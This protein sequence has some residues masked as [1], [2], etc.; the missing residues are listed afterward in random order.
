M[1]IIDGEVPNGSNEV[2]RARVEEP[3]EYPTGRP[4]EG[5]RGL[6]K[7]G[8]GSDSDPGDCND[9][10][11]IPTTPVQR[12][13][14]HR[15]PAVQ[16]ED[17]RGERTGDVR[18]GGKIKGY[19]GP[20][21][22]FVTNMQELAVICHSMDEAVKKHGPFPTSLQRGMILIMEEFGEVARDVADFTRS[23]GGEYSRTTPAIEHLHE[24]LSQLAGLCALMMENIA[25]GRYR[26]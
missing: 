13:D 15:G 12:L 14:I 11:E 7:S 21:N 22:R 16:A 4:I 19:Q 20:V 18:D 5:E 24:E 26:W 6:E 10:P 25:S 17:V 23:H 3:V 2:R 1:R 9:R 8:G